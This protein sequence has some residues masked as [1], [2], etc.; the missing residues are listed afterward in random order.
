MA[1]RSLGFGLSVHFY[2]ILPATLNTAKLRPTYL[3][4]IRSIRI[5]FPRRAVVFEA[6]P[7]A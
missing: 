4:S 1:L 6:C 2:I 5:S 3:L 7:K